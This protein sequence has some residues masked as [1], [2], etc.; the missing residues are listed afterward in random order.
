MVAIAG[1]TTNPLP[2]S[3]PPLLPSSQH[4]VRLFRQ[5][6]GTH[7]YS[8]LGRGNVRVTRLVQEHIM[9]HRGNPTR[10]LKSESRPKFSADRKA[11]VSPIHFLEPFRI[12]CRFS[13]STFRLT[14]LTN[15]VTQFSTEADLE[16]V[17]HIFIWI[18]GLNSLI[19][20]LCF[21]K[22]PWNEKYYKHQDLK[23]VDWPFEVFNCDIFLDGFRKF[24]ISPCALF[25][26]CRPKHEIYLISTKF[27][28]AVNSLI[29]L[30][31]IGLIGVLSIIVFLKF[32]ADEGILWPFWG[33]YK[34]ECS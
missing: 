25:S 15:S 5:F 21:S 32:L 7:L 1:Y 4:L 6:H 12:F 10:P 20:Q 3:P 29:N 24:S 19:H 34:R 28:M 22:C 8:W 17:W 14:S 16:Q 30:L 18:L 11:L 27:W 9:N 13:T 33:R 2:S 26:E 31:K 23:Y